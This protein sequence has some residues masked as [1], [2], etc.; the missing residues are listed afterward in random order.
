M[1][2]IL[3]QTIKMLGL[4]KTIFHSEAEFQFKLAWEIKETNQNIEVLF[5]YPAINIKGNHRRTPMIDLVFKQDGNIFPVEVK[6]AKG[7]LEFGEYKL[8]N[9]P[10]DESID[11][12][13]D[14]RRIEDFVS[15]YD[16]CDHGYVIV[17]SNHKKW[18]DSKKPDSKVFSNRSHLTDDSNNALTGIIDYKTGIDENVVEIKGKYPTKWSDYTVLDINHKNNTFKYLIFEIKK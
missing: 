1:K 8:A 5:E 10:T 18:F 14:I 4:K 13:K 2:Q 17:L 12:I 11:V 16:N 3:D 9:K 15:A 7:D 6:Y